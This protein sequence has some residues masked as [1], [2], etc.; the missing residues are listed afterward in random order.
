MSTTSL[1]TSTSAGHNSGYA[2]LA[3]AGDGNEPAS[4]DDLTA[5]WLV[6]FRES[7]HTRE[8][9]RRDL[10]NF[11][12]WCGRRGVDPVTARRPHLD[13]YLADRANTIN[14]NTG[15]PYAP[16]SL[17]RQLS[18]V[19][20]WYSYLVSAGAVSTNPAELVRRPKIDRDHTVTIGLTAPEVRAFRAAAVND[21][22]LGACAPVLADFIAGVGARVTE[23][24][25]ADVED[26]GH[27]SGHRIIR[28][29]MKGGKT[30]T[31]AVP[32]SLAAAIDDLLDGRTAGPVFV[33]A[34]GLRLNRQ[35]V[36]R[37]V[38][39]T[40][41]K[42]GIAAADQITPHSFRHAW[43]T[44]AR[45]AGATLEERQFALGHADPRTTQRYDRARENLDRDP[46][47][48]VVAATSG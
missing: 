40:A 11:L 39:R 5:E 16:S 17:A 45:A 25:A 29:R 9:Y 27:D 28:L 42:A 1:V 24:C 10:D 43:A 2:G 34:K 37:F 31:R 20:S 18:T 3:L 48:L 19:S 44:I 32:P 15:K 36:A 33:N 23:V 14:E 38:T 21:R 8:A 47:Y 13:A 35:E 12:H 4:L 46:S 26:L 41:K 6:Q 30:R 7:R 22:W